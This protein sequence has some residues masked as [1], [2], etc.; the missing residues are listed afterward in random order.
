MKEMAEI[1]TL[2]GQ[3]LA[4]QNNANAVTN[5]KDHVDDDTLTSRP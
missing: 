4:I 5:A 1:K 3:L 2:K